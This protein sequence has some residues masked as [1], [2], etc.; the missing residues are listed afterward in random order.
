MSYGRRPGLQVPDKAWPGYIHTG[1]EVFTLPERLPAAALHVEVIAESQSAQGTFEASDGYG[2]EYSWTVVGASE[3]AIQ[4]TDDALRELLF[5]Q[6]DQADARRFTPT[7]W[8]PDG[9]RVAVL[10]NETMAGGPHEVAWLG[11]DDTG[12]PVASGV[13][14]SRLLAG[15]HSQV[16][17]MT[18]MK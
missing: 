5:A 17:K 12:R 3:D 11:R 7:H 9:R 10:V 15:P 18:L 13:Y 2:Y 4:R 14:F 16:K 8:S 1:Q 6:P